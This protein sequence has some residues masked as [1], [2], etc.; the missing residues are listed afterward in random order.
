[1]ECVELSLKEEASPTSGKVKQEK[2][3]KE[4]QQKP[5]PPLQLSDVDNRLRIA[6][7]DIR[8]SE[9]NPEEDEEEIK[10]VC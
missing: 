3:E 10:E 1:M 4:D 8:N 7:K 2:D 9:I 6:S 5:R